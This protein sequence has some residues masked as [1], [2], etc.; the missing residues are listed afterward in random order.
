[1]ADGSR[2]RPDATPLTFLQG[3]CRRLLTSHG[4]PAVWHAVYQG[5]RYLLPFATTDAA[6]HRLR[7]STPPITN[8]PAW[9]SAAAFSVRVTLQLTN[10]QRIFGVGANNAS[11][12]IP[13]G[14]LASPP[15]ATRHSLRLSGSFDAFHQRKPR[16]FIPFYC[17][18]ARRTITSTTMAS[19]ATQTPTGFFP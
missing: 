11:S 12:H 10:P 4:N 19:F 16:H 5:L 6:R 18:V 1:V 15:C 9:A 8:W 17:T 2:S 13:E 3:L 14:W 7:N